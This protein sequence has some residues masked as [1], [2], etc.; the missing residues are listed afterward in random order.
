M[1][2]VERY[3]LLLQLGHWFRE[4]REVLN[5]LPV[6]TCI[7]MKLRISF[8]DVGEGSF[9]NVSIFTVSTSIPS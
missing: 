3:V 5:E 2:K 1:I 4:F 8:V 9:S 6:E 7:N